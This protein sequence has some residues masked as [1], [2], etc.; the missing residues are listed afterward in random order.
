MLDGTLPDHLKAA[1]EDEGDWNGFAEY[2]E[3]TRSV[4]FLL[5]SFPSRLFFLFCD[6]SRCSVSSS[7]RFPRINI[8]ARQVF[9]GGWDQSKT[10]LDP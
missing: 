5:S 7:L 10:T 3:T 8:N 6:Q 9:P 2:L 4:L 1:A